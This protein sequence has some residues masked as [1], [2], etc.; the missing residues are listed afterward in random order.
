M[1][2]ALGFEQTVKLLLLASRQLLG[3]AARRENLNYS[4]LMRS[5]PKVDRIV[6]TLGSLYCS[7]TLRSRLLGD[8]STSTASWPAL[9]SWWGCHGDSPHS[10]PCFHGDSLVRKPCPSGRYC[11]MI[12]THHFSRTCT[13]RRGHTSRSLYCTLAPHNNNRLVVGAT[14]CRSNGT[15]HQSMER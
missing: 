3:L 5:A 13:V 8:C 11:L 9:W 6:S 12:C 4:S 2:R 1:I 14:A 15:C 10:T 7:M